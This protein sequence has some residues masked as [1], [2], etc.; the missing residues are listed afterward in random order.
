MKKMR[1]IQYLRTILN[2]KVKKKPVKNLIK[3]IQ[4]SFLEND[5]NNYNNKLMK[6]IS[7]DCL[8]KND[9]NFELYLLY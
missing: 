6:K 1:K 7:N 5:N 2:I 3:E 8:R 9:N 4:N